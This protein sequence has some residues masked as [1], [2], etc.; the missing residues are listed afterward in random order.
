M[1]QSLSELLGIESSAIKEQDA[2]DPIL[3]QD[4]RL[5]LD[6]YLIKFTDIPEFVSSYE[7]LH[8]RFRQI[9]LLLRRS[10]SINDLFWMQA[11]RLMIW[12][13]VKGLCIGF[14]SEG[15]SG[16][17]SGRKTRSSLIRIAKTIIDAGREEPE[18]FELVGLLQKNFGADHISDMVANIIED[19]LC[20]FTKRVFR[21]LEV[22]YDEILS[23]DSV[24]GLPINPHTSEPFY[25]VPYSLLRDLP[26]AFDWSE[27]DLIAENNQRL[28]DEVNEIIGYSWKQ[29]VSRKKDF[30]R[31]VV[32]GKLELFDDL[33]EKY[34]A[35][36]CQPY[37]FSEDR[38]G[39][40]SWFAISREIANRIPLSI[41]TPAQPTIDQVEELVLKICDHFTKLIE[42]NGLN[43]LLYESNGKPKHESASQLLFY[44]ICDAYCN[45]N[46]IM[47]ARE[48]NAGR[49]PVDF[50][51][52][53]SM[54]NSVLVELKKST[55][56]S[57]LKSGILK[58]LPQYMRSEGSRRA[59]YL[60]IQ[61]KPYSKS[62]IENLNEI[63]RKVIGASIKIKY[64]N[65]IPQPS[66][67]RL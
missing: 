26:Q 27:V 36:D 37:D 32:L 65:A 29:A 54:Q 2:F 10:T 57:G 25:L 46:N 62:A 8:E 12:P 18:I 6:P 58:Q 45:A 64:V 23:F 19:D 1:P 42:D 13:E 28:R 16:S 44:G 60:V 48:S 43:E 3:D 4:T 9:G 49:G 63:H 61:V 31:D 30:L 51:F 7:K 50:K 21:N 40:Y 17:G 55:N 34:R 33:L 14:T 47:I 15:T 11:D 41:S 39:E 38:S 20:T 5:F 22:E 52:G 59:I 35:K 56:T 66:A 67:S 24:S 53:T